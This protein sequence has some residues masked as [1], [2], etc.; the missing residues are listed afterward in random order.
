MNIKKIKIY[1]KNLFSKKRNT[2]FSIKNTFNSL[3]K[4]ESLKFKKRKKRIIANFLR[5]FS[6][7]FSKKIFIFYGIWF[8]FVVIIWII[9]I[10]LWPFLNIK[11][12]YITRWDINVNI[13]LAYRAVDFVR[14]KKIFSIKEFDIKKSILKYQESIQDIDISF[15]IPN[16]IN[17]NITDYNSLFQTTLL[18]KRY[19]ILEN[20]AI[21]PLRNSSDKNYIYVYM[22]KKKIPHFPEY[23]KIFQKKYIQSILYLKN[24][25]IE[26][27]ITLKIK[28]IHY[29]VAEREVIIE[30]EKWWD[31]IF[32]LT[33]NLSAQI[34]KIVIFNKES[35]DITKKNL[36]YT[37]LRIE[38]K[39]FF[40][41]I[42]SEFFCRINLKNIYGERKKEIPKEKEKE[43]NSM[44]NL[45]VSF[46]LPQ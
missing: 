3:P 26:N 14:W 30:L 15:D 40:C 45:P 46:P 13:D 24:S 32:D 11:E 6:I 10:F 34:E 4:Q 9:T 22:N 39:V 2:G 29:Y 43:K 41:D 27:M 5:K 12:I 33:K 20:W 7:S 28:N 21:I 37:D 44:Q 38:N 8:L 31:L 17:I 42:T 18:W 35:G 19:L 1:F 16:T 36:I 25:L 23:K